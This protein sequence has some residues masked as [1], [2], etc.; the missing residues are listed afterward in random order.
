MVVVTHEHGFGGAML[1]QSF[2]DERYRSSS[3]IWSGAPNPQLV[4]E[5]A[6]LTPGSALDVGCGEGAD[7]VWLAERGWRVTGVDISA[8]ALQ[9]AAANAQTV[10]ADVAARIDWQHAD[11]MVTA[12]DGAPYDLV[13]AAFMQLPNPQRDVLFT[14]LAASVAPGG[15][16]LV[17]GHHPL[18]LQTKVRRPPLPELFYTA[19]DVAAVLVADDWEVEV[20][21]ARPRQ[22]LEP[23]GASVTIHDTVLRAGR[24]SA[25][26]T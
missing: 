23:D 12:P 17:V 14:W 2:W 19:D 7:A 11:L 22:V 10:G 8:V 9:R 21:E 4:A 16:L 18:D 26:A 24:R 25:P 5:A 6:D 3:S 13:T 20:S 15:T 1:D